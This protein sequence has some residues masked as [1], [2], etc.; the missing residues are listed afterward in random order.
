MRLGIDLDNVLNNLT[1][2]LLDIYNE[3]SGDNISLQEIKTYKVDPYLKSEYKNKLKDYFTIASQK[4]KPIKD[5]TTYLEKLHNEG[6]EIYI[7]TASYYLNMVTKFDWIRQYYP[8]VD[9]KHIWVVH[10]KQMVNV[11]CLLD[12]NID[13]LIGGRYKKFLYVYP[14]NEHI[15]D[16]DI[17][18]IHN[19]KEFYE[20]IQEL[21]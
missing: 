18:K 13:N 17:I 1:E 10:K 4:V 14:W 5:S 11:D 8:F 20:K 9:K 21:S 19:W 2:V 7:L 12:D 16:E 6:H 3:D 15:N